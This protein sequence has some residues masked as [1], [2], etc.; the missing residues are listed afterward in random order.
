MKNNKSIVV[1]ITVIFTVMALWIQGVPI[2]AYKVTGS[3]LA[4]RSGETNDQTAPLV[5][6]FENV[7]G[8]NS[9]YGQSR[10]AMV[11]DGNDLYIV[12]TQFNE[13]GALGAF[14]TR[15]GDN[16][17]N[18]DDPVTLWNYTT[19]YNLKTTILLQNNTLYCFISEFKETSWTTWSIHCLEIPLD[20]WRN[21]STYNRTRVDDTQQGYM[22]DF[23]AIS[24]K[25]EIY[26]FWVRSHYIDCL[27]RIRSTDGNWGV[28]RSLDAGTYTSI[29]SVRVSNISGT[30]TIYFLHNY[31]HKDQ[32]YL[33]TSTNG[34][35]WTASTD[36]FYLSDST[37]LMDMVEFNGRLHM[38]VAERDGYDIYY[39][40][41]SN[42]TAWLPLQ[43]IGEKSETVIDGKLQNLSLAITGSLKTGNLY[44]AHDYKDGIALYTS[45]NNGTTFQSP[46]ILNNSKNHHPN[47]DVNGEFLIHSYDWKALHIRELWEHV[48]NAT[49]PDPTNNTD[50]NST[51]DPVDDPDDNS[52]NDPVDDPDDNSTN[53]PV[54]DPDD[55]HTD[56]P[57]P[58]P[59]ACSIDPADVMIEVEMEVGEEKD[60]I[61]LTFNIS[62]DLDLDEKYLTF[63]WRSEE[64]GVLGDG[65]DLLIDLPPGDHEIILTISGPNGTI[66]E[67]SFLLN[68]PNKEEK[69]KAQY[70]GYLIF[71]V[72][73]A[74]I[75]IALM[76]TIIMFVAP[77]SRKKKHED[78]PFST[79]AQ[80]NFTNDHHYQDNGLK[81][82]NIHI[83]DYEIVS[84]DPSV[85]DISTISDIPRASPNRNNIRSISS[86]ETK[87]ELS[88]LRST[89]ISRSFHADQEPKRRDLLERSKNQFNNG[90]LDTD[91]YYAIKELLGKKL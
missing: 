43:K 39:S 44:L 5:S 88:D 63:I 67:K 27:Y 78:T 7:S 45:E 90:E 9:A 59:M 26:I 10:E 82:G 11:R 36:L 91:S 52:T 19:C 41:T 22:A 89:V 65:K 75:L 35:N 54:D 87:Y 53:D 21:T 49:T 62:S 64:M 24:F 4:T 29:F 86:M 66:V 60:K 40:S 77:R 69:D 20:N 79:R 32:V 25:G 68:V 55:N 23:Q 3:E 81:S 6:I 80:D 2:E 34:L 51:N 46:L 70:S 76:I 72:A 61:H 48:S 73:I 71:G 84:M 37:H 1:I 58:E 42:G 12:T 56:D 33:S 50:D 31:W 57:A 16:G 83:N 28:I 8:G 13:S 74:L 85:C 18:W 15:S 17:T 14:L 30:E 47:F 38:V